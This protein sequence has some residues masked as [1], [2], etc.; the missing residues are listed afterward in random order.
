MRGAS[1]QRVTLFDHQIC[2]MSNKL[3]LSPRYSGDYYCCYLNRRSLIP[4][5]NHLFVPGE[6]V[7]NPFDYNFKVLITMDKIEIIAAQR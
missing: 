5:K 6:L 4:L 2:K 3:S 1:E 7:F